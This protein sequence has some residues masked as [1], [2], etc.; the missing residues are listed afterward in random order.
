MPPH[1][2]RADG[3][4]LHTAAT[5]APGQTV[6][7]YDPDHPDRVSVR[8][9]PGER[10]TQW[11]RRR[12]LCRHAIPRPAQSIP[13]RTRAEELRPQIDHHNDRYH[14]LDN[15][16]ITDGEYDALVRELR[17]IEVDHPDL[18]V[19]D[20]PTAPSV[21]RRRRCSPRWSTGGR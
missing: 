15:P 7:L 11:A 6:A 8:G 13:T 19:P 21:P 20:S 1:R 5:V 18:V 17:S 4:V 3:E 10:E 12:N 16:E 9:S 14:R 2:R